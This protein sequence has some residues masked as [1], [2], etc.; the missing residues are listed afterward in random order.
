M[1]SSYNNM[2]SSTVVPVMDYGAEYGE[3]VIHK[4][5]NV[6]KIQAARAFMGVHT[7]SRIEGLQGDL[8]W[9]RCRIRHKLN[10]LRCWKRLKLHVDDDL[11]AKHVSF[12]TMTSTKITEADI[13]GKSCL[14]S[15]VV[16]ICKR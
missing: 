7:F 13:L 5:W 14:K 9:F 8:P 10:A 11:L 4:R 12:G 6:Q 1:F 16:N 15:L 3:F 2:Y